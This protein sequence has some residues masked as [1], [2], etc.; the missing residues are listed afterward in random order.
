MLGFANFWGLTVDTI[1]AI[2]V[3]ISI[4]LCVDYSAHIAH[5]FMTE[6]GTRGDRTDTRN[7]G[8]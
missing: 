4:G 1:F 8:D 2:F 6:T 7:S 3:M 5:Q